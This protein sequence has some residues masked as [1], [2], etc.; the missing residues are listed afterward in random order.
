M[1]GCGVCLS[2]GYDFGENGFQMWTSAFKTPMQCCECGRVIPAG[3]SHEK[4][5]YKDDDGRWITQHTCAV[6]AEIAWAFFCESRCYE[7]LWD[8][9]EDVYEELSPACFQRLKT[10]AAKAE[11]QRRWMKWKG[12]AE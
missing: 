1:S 4:A 9:M 6:C 10:P 7:V 11:L 8:Y 3:E 2:A 5:R 12:I